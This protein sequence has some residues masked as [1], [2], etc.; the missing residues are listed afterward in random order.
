MDKKPV[1][2]DNPMAIPPPVQTINTSSSNLY[3]TSYKPTLNPQPKTYQ[4]KPLGTSPNPEE[5]K[6]VFNENLVKRYQI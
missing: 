2:E 3:T 5:Y 4:Y 6:S 1:Q